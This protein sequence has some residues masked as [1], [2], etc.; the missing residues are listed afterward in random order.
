[1]YVF[2]FRETFKRVMAITYPVCINVIV[3]FCV[4]VNSQ[5]ISFG[6]IITMYIFAKLSP[7]IY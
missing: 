6:L 4:H 7:Y 2:I 3:P 5:D 1:M